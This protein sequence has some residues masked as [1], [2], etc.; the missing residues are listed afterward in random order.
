MTLLKQLTQEQRTAVM[1]VT[2]DIRVLDYADR[3]VN[4]VDG[5]IVS[6]VAVRDA[7]LIC[8]FLQTV[9][10]FK[11]LT[12]SQLTSI[13]ER[14]KKRRYQRGEMVIR[15]GE[16]GEEFFLIAAG[17]VAVTRDE[18]GSP[19]QWLRAL[20]E[21]DFFGEGALVTGEPRS[22]NVVAETELETYV[23]GKG[24]FPRRHGDQRNLQGSVV[25]NVL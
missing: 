12:L 24:R 16:I 20:D 6:D 2:H 11:D 4:M 13:A 15:Q 22:A 23:L 10:L 21:G 5:V 9:D 3:I 8:E 19:A 7:V 1:V 17:S 14:M 18:P 25:T